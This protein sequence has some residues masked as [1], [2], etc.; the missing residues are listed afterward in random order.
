[1]LMVNPLPVAGN[2]GTGVRLE[3]APCAYLNLRLFDARTGQRG[4]P[5]R[6]HIDGNR[7]LGDLKAAL[8]QFAMDL[9]GAQSG[10]S[11]LIPRITPGAQR[12]V[13]PTQMQSTWRA[14]S[15]DID[16]LAFLSLPIWIRAHIAHNLDPSQ[17]SGIAISD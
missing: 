4:P 2:P 3:G 7:G 9:G 17:G 1:M 8:E 15:E 10:F 11:K 12:V 5:P 14:L 16:G 6:H 13:G